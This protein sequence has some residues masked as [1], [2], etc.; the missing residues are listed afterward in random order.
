MNRP[1]ITLLELLV[2]LSLL[3]IMAT[4][5]GLTIQT[6]APRHSLISVEAQLAH[7]RDS[8]VAIGAPVSEVV[9]DSARGMVGMATALPDGSVVSD[10]GHLDRWTGRSSDTR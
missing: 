3:G 5:A 2:V 6:A 4:I 1:G 8:A 9:S 7:L 10:I